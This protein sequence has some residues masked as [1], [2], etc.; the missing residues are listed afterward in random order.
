MDPQLAVSDTGGVTVVKI[1]NACMLDGEAIQAVGNQLFD[2]VDKD[3]KKKLLI[4]FA[5]IRFMSSQVLGI[6]LTLRRKAEKAGANIVLTCIRQNL[7]RVFE[8]TNLNKMFDFYA[9]REEGLAHFG[10]EAGG[11]GDA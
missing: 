3:A 5:D 8:I 9:S 1:P 4:D 6:L 11:S 2:L 10:C 7:M